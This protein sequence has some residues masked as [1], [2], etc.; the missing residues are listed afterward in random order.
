SYTETNGPEGNIPEDFQGEILGGMT[1]RTLDGIEIG[2]FTLGPINIDCTQEH[3]EIKYQHH[4][5]AAC[6]VDTYEVDNRVQNLG[7]KD[8][9]V[10]GSNWL[11][12]DDGKEYGIGYV[13]EGQ[14]WTGKDQWGGPTGRIQEQIS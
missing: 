1:V 2:Q 14:G 6:L 4:L 8:I 3:E 13:E 5:V 12:G 11:V 10:Y 7:E 9:D